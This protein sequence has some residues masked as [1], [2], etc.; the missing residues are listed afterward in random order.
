M[1]LDLMTRM[2]YDWGVR[3]FGREHMIDKPTR[4][5]RMLE[6]AIELTQSLSV[7]REQAHELVDYVYDR[8]PG[9]P[10]QEAG[11]TLLTISV[12]CH[13]LG[14]TPERV[15][16]TE[17][18]RCQS[19]SPEYFA[20]RNK[21]KMRVGETAREEDEEEYE[22]E[23][24]RKIR[25]ERVNNSERFNYIAPLLMNGPERKEVLAAA[26]AK[27]KKVSQTRAN[28]Q[29]CAMFANATRPHN[30]DTKD[31]MFIREYED[32]SIKMI[33]LTKDGREWTINRWTSSAP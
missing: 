23:K 31:K 14:Q 18:M 19:K 2:A 8:P 24:G 16:E 4:S 17:L 15:Y 5:L 13:A 11:G 1:T 21:E 33:E 9:D 29:L 20:A 26:W 27:R 25:V 3:C 7:S 28:S 6:E 12:L 30:G 32:N 10:I 22:E